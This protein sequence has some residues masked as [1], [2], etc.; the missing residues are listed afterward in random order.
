MDELL[1]LS[2]AQMRRIEPF[3][4]CRMVFRAWDDRRV[5]SAGC[6]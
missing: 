1:L 5:L 2:E 3:F 6:P 4:L